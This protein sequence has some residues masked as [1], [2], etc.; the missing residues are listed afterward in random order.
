M[1]GGGDDK[2]GGCFMGILVM[3]KEV[4]DVIVVGKME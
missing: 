1:D 4:G 3:K 2:E